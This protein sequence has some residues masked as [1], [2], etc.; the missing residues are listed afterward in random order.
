M[1]PE[2]AAY[3]D[4]LMEAWRKRHVNA[5]NPQ[6]TRQVLCRG[7]CNSW[8]LKFVEKFPHLKRVAG[9]ACNPKNQDDSLTPGTEHWWC[10]D[11]DGTIVDPTAEQFIVDVKY[12]ELDRVRH[13]VKIGRCIICGWDIYGTV[14]KGPRS[15][16]DEEYC[17]EE[18]N[19][20]RF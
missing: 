6:L 7:M 9:F 2:Y 3:R 11:T 14:D 12:I 19:A 1:K 10:V 5:D 4:E 15:I 17:I 13:H 18:A 8:T 16:C 20:G